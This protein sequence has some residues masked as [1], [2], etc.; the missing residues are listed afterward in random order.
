MDHNGQTGRLHRLLVSESWQLHLVSLMLVSGSLLGILSMP[1]NLYSE[2]V[3]FWD[4][5]LLSIQSTK[6]QLLFLLP[7]FSKFFIVIFIAYSSLYFW[8]WF[9]VSKPRWILVVWPVLTQCGLIYDFMRE[10]EINSSNAITFTI[11]K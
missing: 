11:E 7:L 8:R 1:R 5:R 2:S 10:N 3:M 9:S 4:F 6:K